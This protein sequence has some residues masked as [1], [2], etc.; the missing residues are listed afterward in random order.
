MFSS[1][2]LFGYGAE[3]TIAM[4]LITESMPL[5]SYT[6]WTIKVIYCM[7][8]IFQYPVMVFPVTIILD[9]YTLGYF[10][11]RKSRVL[12][13]NLTRLLY[14]TLTA[15][16]ALTVYNK[17]PYL[18]AISGAIACCPLGF[19]LPALFHW[20][21]GLAQTTF[22]KVRNICLLIFSV[23]ATCFTAEEVFRTWSK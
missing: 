9:S 22:A 21:L 5:K 2:S 19:T 7:V 3:Q 20:K 23:I 12:V 15:I 4:P 11:R 13:G 16:I 10:R 1:Y 17:M 14:V 18:N 6:T 8:L